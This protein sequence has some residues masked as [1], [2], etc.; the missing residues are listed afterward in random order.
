M[1]LVDINHCP[2]Y[3]GIERENNVCHKMTHIIKVKSNGMI[4]LNNDES[5]EFGPT[6]TL[7]TNTD[8][9]RNLNRDS[10]G[11]LKF[12]DET[13]DLVDRCVESDSE[14]EKEI[15]KN[16]KLTKIQRLKNTISNL[17]NESINNN[18]E[19]CCELKQYINKYFYPTEVLNLEI[20]EF[21]LK[22]YPED[23]FLVSRNI[24]T[25]SIEESSDDICGIIK[26]E[27]SIQDIG[28]TKQSPRSCDPINGKITNNPN[29][30][31]DPIDPKCII[32]LTPSN[33]PNYDFSLNV[34][35]SYIL[36][37]DL[38]KFTNL[39]GSKQD[40]RIKID[41]ITSRIDSMAPLY[42]DAG[43]LYILDKVRPILE[44]QWK[45]ETDPILAEDFYKSNSLIKILNPYKDQKFIIIGDLHGSFATFIRI[46]LRLRKMGIM[47]KFGC[48]INNYH[49]IF[50]GDIVDRG[51]Y[52]YEIIMLL[53]CLNILNPNNIHL[54]RGNH[55]E[56]SINS[57]IGRDRLGWQMYKQFPVTD[58]TD[59]TDQAEELLNAINHRMLRQSSA[60]IIKNPLSDKY[61]YLAHG[62]LPTTDS[63]E[64]DPII[65]P[66]NF[67]E[68]YLIVP[69]V[70]RG[71]IRW[72]DFEPIK[73]SKRSGRSQSDIFSI[74]GYD[75]L[76]EARKKGIELIIRGHLDFPSNTKLLPILA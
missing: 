70:I 34:N 69:D 76:S 65:D 17:A 56:E 59:P 3:K 19:K 26:T 43:T 31:T 64:L 51:V 47:D 67:K 53:Y 14:D 20:Y 42:T 5:I 74:I 41:P 72:N 15:R 66:I 71:R 44:N 33:N 7:S 6:V 2:P 75:T 12:V 46:L 22:N 60:I 63:H 57:G 1:A 49:V 45:K 61:I 36:S 9:G 32:P 11:I 18:H 40:R 13:D 52:G 24:I 37:S 50:L 23:I 35:G 58:P 55:E 27:P 10:F 68:K 30:P 29:N 21:L 16:K 39:Y 28:T 25:T 73:I 38:I 62:G 4:Y 8:F 48:L 54:N